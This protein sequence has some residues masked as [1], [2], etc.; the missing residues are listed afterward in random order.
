MDT[1]PTAVV[2]PID[3]ESI[4]IEPS[5]NNRTLTRSKSIGIDGGTPRS[6]VTELTLDL[7]ACCDLDTAAELEERVRS[8]QATCMWTIVI[9]A[10]LF[11]VAIAIA[12]AITSASNDGL[13][14][15][16]GGGGTDDMHAGHEHHTHHH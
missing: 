5:E 9:G 3:P 6:T 12:A 1:I 16:L 4:V 15:S 8:R 2:R 10:F 14:G 7:E 13:G 11:C